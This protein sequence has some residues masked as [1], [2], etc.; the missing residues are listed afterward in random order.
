M[1]LR[2]VIGF[3]NVIPPSV[4]TAFVHSLQTPLSASTEAGEQTSA[5]WAALAHTEWQRQGL[6]TWIAP[7]PKESSSPLL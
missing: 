4:V 3:G 5:E 7:L 1:V 2:V 6:A